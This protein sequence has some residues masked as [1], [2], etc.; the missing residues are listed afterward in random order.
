MHTV[1][2]QAH[3]SEA[4][5][6]SHSLY[7]CFC[8]HLPNASE[9]LRQLAS[10]SPLLAQQLTISYTTL[11]PFHIGMTQLCICYYTSKYHFI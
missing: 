11:Y 7:S 3:P 1:F 2:I 10:L 4:L 8:E 5:S 9:P 6:L